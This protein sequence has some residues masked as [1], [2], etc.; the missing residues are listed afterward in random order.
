V[1]Q[2]LEPQKGKVKLI[3]IGKKKIP[4]KRERFF[5][6]VQKV[7]NSMDELMGGMEFESHE[8][9]TVGTRSTEAARIAGEGVP[10]KCI[11]NIFHSHVLSTYA[12]HMYHQHMPLTCNIITGKA[13]ARSSCDPTARY[14]FFNLVL[15]S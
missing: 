11:K 15:Y 2:V 13:V 7:S 3:L 10:L 9:K 14:I 12:S 6:F 4:N 5:G 1:V 8:T